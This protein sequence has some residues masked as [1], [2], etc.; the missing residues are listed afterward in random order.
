MKKLMTVSLMLTIAL[1]LQA[2]VKVAPKMEKGTMKTYATEAVITIPSQGDVKM[3]TDSKFT[4]TDATADGYVLE[5]VCTDV[6][7][8]CE[9]GNIAGKLMAAAEEMMKDAVVRAAVDKNG[10]VQDILNADEV[11]AGLDANA[12]AFIDQLMTDMPQLAGVVSKEGLKKQVSQSLTIDALVQTLQEATSP[13]ALNDK[14][15]MTGAQEEF[16]NKEGIKI[17][18]L[19]F[20]NGKTIIANSTINMTEDEIKQFI[21]KQVEQSA[22]DQAQMIKD[23]IDQ[24]M[25]SG[26]LKMDFKESATYELQDDGWVKSI[27]VD[28][29]TE[30][31]GQKVVSKS[32]VTLK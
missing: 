13:L 24:L 14:T 16:V 6:K 28:S 25:K 18:R 3:T 11:K 8:E 1:A 12:D 31:M 4:I 27:V 29:S 2:Q 22:P 7:T 5:M 19:Y 21:I 32:T 20:V 9:P 17:K 10:R 26:M 23:N 15:I 30:T